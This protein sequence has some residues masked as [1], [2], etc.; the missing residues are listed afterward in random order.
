MNDPLLDILNGSNAAGVAGARP[1]MPSQQ[2]VS[3]GDDPLLS[4]VHGGA[5][6]V[7]APAKPAPP[8]AP[9]L[10]PS[11]IDEL[12]HQLGLTARAGVTG[13]AGLPNMVGDA[14]NTAINLGSSSVNK[15]AGTNI[16]MMRMPSQ[17]TQNLMNQAGF[18]QPRNGLEQGVQ[19]AA[20]A[21]AGVSPSVAMG[22]ALARSIKPTVGFVA[23]AGKSGAA[24]QTA[25][26]LG[27]ALQA[28]PGMQML[29]SAGAGAGAS[30]AAQNGAGIL[31]QLGAGA[32]G[33]LAGMAGARIGS[34]VMAPSA[35]ATMQQQLAQAL[36]DQENNA[37][38]SAPKPRLKLNI[39]G[40]TQEVPPTLT[41]PQADPLA[42]PAAAPQGAA[43]NSQRQL[44]NI[45][46]M[47]KIG[48]NDQRPAAISGDRH[49]A[50]VEYEESKLTSP[51]GEVM[52]AQLQKEQDALKGF[53]GG[54]VKD[55]GASQAAA[56]EAV[57]Q[58]IRAPMQSLSDHFDTAIGGLYDQAKQVAGTAA[59]VK[60]DYLTAALKDNNFRETFL[61]SPGGTTLLG[62][63]DRQV[64]RFQGLPVDGEPLAVAPNTVT[65]AEN[66]RKWLNGQWSPGNS[67][68][69]G[70]VKEALDND[71]ATAGGAGIFDEARALHALRKNTLDNP[72]GISKLLTSDGPNGINQAIPDEQVATKLL[73]MPTAQFEHVVK[74]LQSLPEPLQQH[75]QQAIAEIK[76]ALA[77]RIQ[78]AGDNGGTQQGPANWNAANVTRELTANKS[79]MDIVFGPSELEK[80]LD[81]H[82]AGHVIQTPTA[83]KGAAAQTYNFMQSGAINGLPTAAAG[84]G[85]L[86]GLVHPVAGAAGAT[87]GSIL[88][89]GASKV[90]KSSVDASRAAALAEALRNPSPSFPR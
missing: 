51:T 70:Q 65:S 7:T 59:P 67:K 57:G 52:R 62:A 85:S 22:K 47:R 25:A 12:G 21:V 27:R 54:L 34:A 56:P 80:F 33:G 41:S 64:K 43:L 35:K 72:D 14:L 66:L 16:P 58:S 9:A 68:L 46:A 60:P 3:G 50:G 5:S 8:A 11:M 40:S 36:R 48:L 18:A 4:L 75:G 32:L 83:Y 84:A 42:I 71:V 45:E 44:A 2:L 39:D 53:A 1:A 87:L 49:Q 82:T 26:A 77:R 55:T 81:L 15:M 63:I 30:V 73:A 6:V 88:G 78:K 69:I 76:G 10:K 31:G 17:E 23:E 20:S 61:S 13:L 28:A 19:A 79:K 74:T 37:A 89:M 24:G 86:L 90:V 29:G 38:G